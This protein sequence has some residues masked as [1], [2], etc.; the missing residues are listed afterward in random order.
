[1]LPRRAEEISVRSLDELLEP[2]NLNLNKGLL[3]DA[4]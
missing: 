1:M 4:A 2:E 3:H